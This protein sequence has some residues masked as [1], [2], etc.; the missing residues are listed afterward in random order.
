MARAKLGMIVTE[1]NGKI[2]G[3]VFRQVKGKTVISTKS[4]RDTS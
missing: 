4:T 2:G 3:N 1:I